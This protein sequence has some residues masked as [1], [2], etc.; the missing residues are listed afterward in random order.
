MVMSE[1]NGEE[2]VSKESELHPIIDNYILEPTEDLL[3]LNE[4]H[5]STLLYN[6]R[7]RYAEDKIYT[8]VGP[9]VVALNPFK[10]L[11]LYSDEIIRQYHEQGRE[12][13][14]Q[15][16]PHIYTIA[17]MSYYSMLT[18]GGNQSIL[19]SGESGAGKVIHFI[20]NN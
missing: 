11:P 15:L 12:N 16:P 10:K 14:A 18:S 19:I 7:R 20:T 6:I 5:E 13:M 3:K 17:E 2:Y 8:Y 4:L 9:I 1:G